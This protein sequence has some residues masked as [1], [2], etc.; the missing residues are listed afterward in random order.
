MKPLMG[1]MVSNEKALITQLDVL[2]SIYH[3]S[4]VYVT[5]RVKAVALGRLAPGACPTGRLSP[6]GTSPS[7]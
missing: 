3:G 6:L 1:S 7:H 5:S 4:E 2:Y